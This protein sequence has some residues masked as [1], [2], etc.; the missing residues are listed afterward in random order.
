[1]LAVLYAA[2]ISTITKRVEKVLEASQ[3]P[4][5]LRDDAPV[6]SLFDSRPLGG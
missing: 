4:K 2:E 3:I 5:I 6:K 1:M